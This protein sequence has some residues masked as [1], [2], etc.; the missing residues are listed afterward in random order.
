MH[1]SHHGSMGCAELQEEQ[2]VTCR[3]CVFFAE[4]NRKSKN[5][6]GKLP[7][8]WIFAYLCRK[9]LEKAIGELVEI[10]I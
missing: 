8:F 6:P 3:V 10:D 2:L 5:I 9:L 1:R 7:F 4:F